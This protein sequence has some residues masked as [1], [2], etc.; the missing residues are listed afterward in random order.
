MTGKRIVK[1]ETK[2]HKKTLAQKLRPLT[3]RDSTHRAQAERASAGTFLKQVEQDDLRSA[4]QV[5]RRVASGKE[6]LSDPERKAYEKAAELLV[7]SLNGDLRDPKRRIAGQL[8]RLLVQMLSS[9][10][11]NERSA[12]N[13]TSR[14]GHR[15]IV[16]AESVRDA[17]REAEKRI[18]VP[19][20]HEPLVNVGPTRRGFRRAPALAPIVVRAPQKKD[21]PSKQPRRVVRRTPHMDLS[22]S[23][24]SPGMFFEISIYADQSA[25]RS[26]EVSAD[27]VVQSGATVEVQLVTSAH[28]RVEGSDLTR[29]VVSE[30]KR[31]EA[32]RIFKVVVRPSNE[33]PIDV[34]PSLIALFFHNGRPCGS[35]ARTITIEGVITTEVQSRSGQIRTDEGAPADL[36]IV[37]TRAIINDGRQFFC[38]VRS[39][40]LDKY[41]SGISE[42]WNLPQAADEIVLSYMER[43][44]A[45]AITPSMLLAELRGAGRQLFDAAPKL[46][47]QALWDLIDAGVE[48]RT[49]AIVTEEPFI[50]WELMI[51]YRTRDGRRQQREALGAEFLVGRW[52]SPDS[53]SPPPY[54]DLV[55]SFVIAPVYAPPLSFAGAEAAMVADCVRGD[56]IAPVD[57]DSITEAFSSGGRTLVHFVCHGED[58]QTQVEAIRGPDN[59]VRN[60]VQVIRL[61]KNQKLNSSQILGIET[62]QKVFDEKKPF[63]F[64]NA[65]EIGRAT[66]ALVGVGGFAKS[67]IEIGAS[68]V[69]APLWAVKDQFAHEVAKTFYARLGAERNTPFAEIIRDLRRRAYEP[70][71]AED[72]FA[73]YCF[74]GDPAACCRPA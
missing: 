6:E 35:V 27:I 68:A 42:P 70:G 67:F 28:F 73:A 30:A 20:D 56:I 7:K 23:V 11:R 13:T 19:A 72:T 24:V 71:Q 38:T 55:D 48:L 9:Q 53:I 54:I 14:S 61:E 45:E 59:R 25:A 10:A 26:G 17:T 74:Y 57:F 49:I 36:I 47:R 66:P 12:G 8:H 16:I 64:L 18:S 2:K 60:R 22:K 50:P 1:T 65:C 33:V 52:P 32:E 43:F 63:V 46:F 37:V 62:L 34:V 69:I 41:R 5:L 58:E 21:D 3:G 15:T 29:I 39:H 31:A 40:R 4:L 44:T 51:P